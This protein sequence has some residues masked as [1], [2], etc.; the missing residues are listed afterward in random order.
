M[1][2]RRPGA[3]RARRSRSLA[4]EGEL[5]FLL[6]DDQVVA[7]RFLVREHGELERLLLE[8][9]GERGLAL[10]LDEELVRP[11]LVGQGG[12]GGRAATGFG[13]L[14]LDA[15]GDRF[16]VD[17][18]VS[19][20]LAGD[21]AGREHGDGGDGCDDDQERAHGTLP[22]IRH[23]GWRHGWS[24]ALRPHAVPLHGS[25]TSLARSAGRNRQETVRN[26]SVVT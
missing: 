25:V 1:A 6:L 18:D 7:R 24:V 22:R 13:H 26:T 3:I 9:H 11:E 2:T 5:A 16:P 23:G 8:E 17:G 14:D 19:E 15:R 10:F 21:G 20:D 12:I 4:T